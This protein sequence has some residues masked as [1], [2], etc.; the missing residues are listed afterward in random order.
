M[1]TWFTKNGIKIT[2]ILFGRSNAFILSNNKSRAL[3]DTGSASDERR[4]LKRLDETGK[5]DSVILTHTHFDHTGNA[6]AVKT[7]F[8]PVYIVHEL[9]KIFLETGDSPLPNGT[10]A[11]T[12]FIYRLG[13]EKV[14]QWFH[15]PGVKA[16]IIFNKNLDLADYGFNTYIL[17]TPGHSPGSS[18]VV[19]EN[20]IALVGDTLVG[21]PVSVF[22][23]WGDD[24]HEIIRSWKRLLDTGCH[25][26]HPAHGWPVSR[27]RLEKEYKK[28][29]R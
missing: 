13:A 12:R 27:E 22:P 10:M 2:R 11:W 18:S 7:R 14:P 29:R 19:V 21:M 24:T 26:F 23:P 9:E 17:H 15:V 25:T 28:S 8:E 5:P 16:T 6:A 20:E 1:K 4:L 3:V